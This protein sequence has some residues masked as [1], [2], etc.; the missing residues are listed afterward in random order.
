[1]LLIT[2]IITLLVAVIVAGHFFTNLTRSFA[3]NVV[4]YQYAMQQEVTLKR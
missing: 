2:R 4:I 3:G 1:M